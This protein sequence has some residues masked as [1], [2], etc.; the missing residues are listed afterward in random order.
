M[1]KKTI[2][3][4]NFNGNPITEDFYFNFTSLEVSKLMVRLG[5]DIDQVAKNIAGSNDQGAMIEFVEELV[6]SSYGIKSVDGK[7]FDKSPEIKHSFSCSAAYAEL[8]EQLLLDP[9]ACIAFGQGLVM[10]ANTNANAD[11]AALIA[12]H[13]A[14]QQSNVTP[15]NQDPIIEG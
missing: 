5:G 4:T 3:Y 12:Q 15:I 1:L 2:T 8:F 14:N 11:K 13:Q 6:L 10:Q 9:Q 7:G